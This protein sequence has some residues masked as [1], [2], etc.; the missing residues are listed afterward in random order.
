MPGFPVRRHLVL[1]L[2]LALAS[3][4]TLAQQA[5]GSTATDPQQA[6]TGAQVP[7]SNVL[8]S[9]E[10]SAKLDKSRNQ[11]S[12]SIGASQYVMDAAAIDRLPLG[13]NTPVNQILLQAPGVVQDSYGEMHVRGDHGDMQYR[14]NGVTLPESISGFGQMIDPDIIERVQLLTGA[15]PA[16]YGYRTAGVVEIITESGAHRHH[17]DKED[18]DGDGDFGGRAGVTLGSHGTFNPELS[19]HGSTNKWSWFLTADYE[20]NN[21]G[22][23]N[24]TKSYQAIHDHSQQLKGF[25]YLS[26]LLNENARINFMFGVANNRFEIPNNPGQTP[27]YSLAGVTT[28]DSAKLDQRQ[29]ET[30][31]FGIVALQGGFGDTDYQVSLG[32]RYTSVDYHPD[33]IGDLVFNGVA[34]T[35]C[36]RRWRADATR[37]VM[38]CMQ[39]ASARSATIPHWCFLPMP[40]A[41][42]PARRRSPS[43]TTRRASTPGLMA[44]TCRTNGASPIASR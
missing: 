1:A 33:P 13:D 4:L 40:M 35:I 44:C 42:R 7:A 25:G 34:G 19:F 18:G 9:V 37:C 31:R 3:P 24:P 36:R 28:A 30:N 41:T 26:Y 27:N 38:G 21:I 22:I 23:E 12:T 2:S 39:A 14:I 16:Q 8:G 10:V 20:K 15:L 5:T 17:D 6:A 32:Q 43:S 11:I 29:R